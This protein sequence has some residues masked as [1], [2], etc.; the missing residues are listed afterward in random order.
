MIPGIALMI[1]AYISLRCFELFAR[2][3]SHFRSYG[4]RI[5]LLF[6]AVITLLIALWQTIEIWN[7]AI[8]NRGGLGLP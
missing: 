4:N 1:G 6:V 7:Q 3:D 8:T 5:A 2:P